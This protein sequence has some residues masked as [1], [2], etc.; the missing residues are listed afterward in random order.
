[1]KGGGKMVTSGCSEKSYVM[2]ENAGVADFNALFFVGYTDKAGR[3]DTIGQF[4]SGFK[5]GLTSALRLGIDVTVY[6]GRE[7]V[8]AGTVRR[9]VK[10]D[11][12]EQ[13]VFHREGPEGM[14]E[15]RETNLT[16]GYGAR[17]WKDE[18]G[19]FR[20][21]LQNAFDADPRGYEVV[22]G[23]APKGRDGFTRVFLEATEGI[24]A[25]YRDLDSFFRDPRDAMFV[26]DQGRVYPKSAPDGQT[27]YYSKGMYVLATKETSLYDLDIYELPINES[28]DASTSSLTHHV[29][30]LFDVCPPDM[31]TEI[32]RF[33][34]Q[35]GEEGV[36][37]LE[38]SLFW[39]FSTRPHMWGDAFKRAFPDHV[40]TTFSSIEYEAMVRM[41]RKAVRATRHL[42]ELL[43]R[44][45]V[46]TAQKILTSEEQARREVFTPQG[47]LAENYHRAFERV[48]KGLPEVNR[49]EVTF[50][51]LPRH[52]RSI[53]FLTISRQRG[54]YQFSETL[55]QAGPK[56][57]AV[58]LVDA[59]TQTR[60]ANGKCHPIYE[61][62]MMDMLLECIDCIAG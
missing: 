45:G 41:G 58:A 16:L 3:P 39:R 18:W 48:A 27:Y 9:K 5:L 7:K 62:H 52:Q 42:Y 46:M 29:L 56:Q 11:D 28:R 2:F 50:I 53:D 21:M 12:V 26:C 24:L 34:I 17:D 14:V 60:S 13:L 55:L 10:G 32:I 33:A 6:L 38:N 8:K 15:T 1:M 22:Y 43:S 25:I 19:V 40:L 20:E 54:E 35:K 36:Q 4:G 59:L 51:R 47:L 31:K 61:R 57:I 37:T 30:R 23:V 44:A 49:L